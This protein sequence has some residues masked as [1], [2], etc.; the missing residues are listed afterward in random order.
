MFKQYLTDKFI[1]SIKPAEPGTRITY[2]D[3]GGPHLGLRVTDN[4]KGRLAHPM[5]RRDRSLRSPS[6]QG[7]PPARE[8]ASSPPTNRRHTAD[9]VSLDQF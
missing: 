9:I 4:P 8:V 6:A 7:Q 2:W 1:K 3:T 5:Q